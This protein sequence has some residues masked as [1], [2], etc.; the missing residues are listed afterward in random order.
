[1]LF[2]FFVLNVDD[3]VD[4]ADEDSNAAGVSNNGNVFGEEDSQSDSEPDD[5]PDE[6]EDD[7][8]SDDMVVV[9]SEPVINGKLLFALL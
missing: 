2:V 8:K 7:D 3:V 5:D 1:M 9:V 4:E 6:L